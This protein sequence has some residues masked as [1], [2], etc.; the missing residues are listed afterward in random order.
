MSE[1]GIGRSGVVTSS[2]KCL[3]LCLELSQVSCSI[4][5]AP[6]LDS[7]RLSPTSYLRDLKF[8]SFF[9][10]SFQLTQAG[11]AHVSLVS[12]ASRALIDIVAVGF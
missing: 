2:L 12:I 1:A 3:R 8:R 4:L 5:L 6:M 7:T 11:Q 10:F 9:S